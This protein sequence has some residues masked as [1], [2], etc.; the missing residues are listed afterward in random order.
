MD[1]GGRKG[2]NAQLMILFYRICCI[3]LMCYAV[4]ADKLLMLIF[5]GFHLVH[6]GIMDVANDKRN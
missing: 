2:M 5:F 6:A 3:G 1:A 4:K